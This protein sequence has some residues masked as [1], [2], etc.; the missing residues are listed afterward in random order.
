MFWH[1]FF[2]SSHNLVTNEDKIVTVRVFIILMLKLWKLLITIF[3]LIKSNPEIGYLHKSL[4]SIFVL[5]YF[6]LLQR[7]LLI[8]QVYKDN[9]PHPTP[10]GNSFL[11]ITQTGS[12]Q[13]QVKLIRFVNVG[14]CRIS[15]FWGEGSLYILLT[16]VY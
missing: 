11:A 6:L 13:W 14:G 7:W 3:M 16:L 15:S 9:P 8:P 1:F 2:P 10:S 4:K 12:V 5:F